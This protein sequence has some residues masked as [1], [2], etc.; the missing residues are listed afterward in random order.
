MAGSGTLMP[1]PPFPDQ[2][3]LRKAEGLMMLRRDG[4]VLL[5]QPSV[6][7][8]VLLDSPSVRLLADLARPRL[9]QDLVRQG[10]TLG[11]GGDQVR[12]LMARLV[13]Q[14]M[15]SMNGRMRPLRPPPRT[16]PS[17]LTIALRLDGGCSPACPRCAADVHD[18]SSSRLDPEA[19]LA[20]VDGAL[21]EW[22]GP[23]TVLLTGGEPLRALPELLAVVEGCLQRARS[24]PG[25]LQP[26]LH[27]R[28][29]LLEEST[30]D[31]LAR[32]DVA[33]ALVL[34]SAAEPLHQ[35][36]PSRQA[37][38][39]A[40]VSNAALG[41][42]MTRG[43]SLLPC[44]VVREPGHF[45]EGF[46]ALVGCGFRT[47]RLVA[48]PRLLQE[49]VP[50]GQ[51]EAWALGFVDMAR[52]AAAFVRGRASTL[53][54]SDL[55]RLVR[56]TV[57][58]YSAAVDALPSVALSPGGAMTAA[59]RCPAEGVQPWPGEGREEWTQVLS[60]GLEVS[61]PL[62]REWAPRCNRCPVQG[63]C[64]SAPLQEVTSGVEVRARVEFM[65]RYY[66]KVFE[67]LL[68]TWQEDPMLAVSVG[69]RAPW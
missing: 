37:G 19:A 14:G 52:T 20:M 39:A 41:R 28:G 17:T 54:V 15:L 33:V 38:P 51:E 5:L 13:E 50:T 18:D 35:G 40:W 53:A 46:E 8:A 30:L 58:G 66:Q 34:D 26:V 59:E 67:E 10:T 49:P 29:E 55:D 23:V 57:A 27:T 3:L 64:G 31:L 48:T 6:P 63:W 1:C 62:A 2:A 22:K 61:H 45:V 24:C 69:G 36:S 60:R 42:L 68:W 56:R 4:R 9:L 32:H 47:F 25:R 11:M 65:C 7:S 44:V 43:I 16:A 21:A 12:A